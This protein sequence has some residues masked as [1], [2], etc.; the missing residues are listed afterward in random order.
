METGVY[1]TKEVLDIFD[2]IK[3]QSLPNIRKAKRIIDSLVQKYNNAPYYT[4]KITLTIDNVSAINLVNI[5]G[6]FFFG[7]RKDTKTNFDDFIKV[8][9]N[10]IPGEKKSTTQVTTNKST[11]SFSKEDVKSVKMELSEDFWLALEKIADDNDPASWALIKF[12]EYDQKK[13]GSNVLGIKFVDINDDNPSL[14]D[15]RFASGQKTKIPIFNFFKQYFNKLTNTEIN[16]FI[17]SLKK[18]VSTGSYEPSNVIKVPDFKFNPK[19]IRS[20]F[21]SLVTETYPKGHEDEVVKFLPKDLIKDEFG[22]YYKVIGDSDVMFTS[23]LDTVSFKTDVTLLSRIVDDNQEIISSDGT[24]ILGADDKAG[25]TVLL[26]MMAHNIPGVY[27][28]FVGEETGGIGSGKVA[29]SYRK[30]PH[31]KKIRKCVSFDRRNYYSVITSQ[32]YDSC[33]SDEFGQALCQELNKSGLKM[34]LDPTGVF[35]DSA[36]FMEIIPECTNVSVGYFNEHTYKEALNITFLER[37]AKACLKV[38]W[39]GLPVYRFADMSQDVLESWSEIIDEIEETGTHN[40]LKYSG[41]KNKLVLK[42]DFEQTSLEEAYND[43]GNLEYIF[44]QYNLQPKITFKGSI[45]KFEIA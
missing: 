40:E 17:Q 32:M 21:I 34:G 42:L 9:N 12:V 36:N 13:P 43:L 33:C 45:I 27:Y 29:E 20:T 8:F 15:V 4:N 6:E 5:L 35:T 44:S 16:D 1:L 14:F 38:D 19:D 24:T 11:T 31:L 10:N 41:D 2:K 28:F 3:K 7:S 18:I 39:Q 37:L 26:Y 23:H 22:N 25:V 30:F